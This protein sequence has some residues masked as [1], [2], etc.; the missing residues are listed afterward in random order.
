M[1]ILSIVLLPIAVLFLGDCFFG[2]YSKQF[3]SY[4]T[5]TQILL[6]VII[7]PIFEEIVFRGLIQDFLVKKIKCKY[8]AFTSVNLLFVLLHIHKN[9]GIIYLMFVFICGMIFSVV[10]YKSSRVLY[11]IVLHSYYN[12]LFILKYW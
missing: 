6:L 7:S 2:D 9:M 12:L 11:P 3:Q 8:L 1:C 10:K 5:N 4:Y